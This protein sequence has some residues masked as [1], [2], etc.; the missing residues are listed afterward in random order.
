[1]A[2]AVNISSPCVGPTWQ[3]MHMTPSSLQII[4]FDTSTKLE[5]H[6]GL[7]SPD[8]FCESVILPA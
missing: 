6:E 5:D 4:D 2:S 7:S 1:M 3:P 8:L